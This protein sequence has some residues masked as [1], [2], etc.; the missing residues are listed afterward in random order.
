M[1]AATSPDRKAF[2]V[3]H[4]ALAKLVR[5]KLKAMLA[6]KRPDR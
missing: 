4:M 1:T 6:N 5:G 2:L 3:S